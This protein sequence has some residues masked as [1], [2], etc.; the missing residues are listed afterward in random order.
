MV[1]DTNK[2]CIAFVFK[3]LVT[4]A[5]EKFPVEEFDVVVD[6]PGTLDMFAT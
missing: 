4:D 3:I 5:F 1:S 6:V 2:G